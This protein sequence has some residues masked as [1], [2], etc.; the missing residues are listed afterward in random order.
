M[1]GVVPNV[2]VLKSFF[3][4]RQLYGVQGGEGGRELE[5]GEGRGALCSF[6]EMRR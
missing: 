2:Y 6:G 4:A 3:F 1:T 5:A